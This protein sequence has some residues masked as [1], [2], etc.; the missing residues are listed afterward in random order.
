MDQRFPSYSQM[1]TAHD[2]SEKSAQVTLTLT[3]GG[4]TYGLT[5]CTDGS[6]ALLEAINGRSFS[7]PV[8]LAGQ[9]VVYRAETSTKTLSNIIGKGS[10]QNFRKFPKFSV[11]FYSPHTLPI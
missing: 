6:H 7:Q 11:E 4:A 5:G 8:C 3:S 2:D 10:Y 1:S 9:L